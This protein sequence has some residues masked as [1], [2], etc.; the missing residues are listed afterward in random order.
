V[1]NAFPLPSNFLQDKGPYLGIM[2]GYG[3]L[4]LVLILIVMKRKDVK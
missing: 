2:T 1:N 3:I 4:V